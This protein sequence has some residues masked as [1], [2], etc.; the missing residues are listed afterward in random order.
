[1]SASVSTLPRLPKDKLLAVFVNTEY[2][3]E[4]LT[5]AAELLQKG[6]EKTDEDEAEYRR[7][8]YGVIHTAVKEI[9]ESY[10]FDDLIPGLLFYVVE[11]AVYFVGNYKKDRYIGACMYRIMIGVC[12]NFMKGVPPESYDWDDLAWNG[13]GNL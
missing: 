9:I 6:E 13:D 8:L 1:M 4:A 11:T 12:S 5:K 3:L 10:S 2:Y 7:L